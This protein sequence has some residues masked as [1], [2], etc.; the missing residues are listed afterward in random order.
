MLKLSRFLSLNDN[1]VQ[2]KFSRLTRTVVMGI[3][4][5]M[6]TWLCPWASCLPVGIGLCPCCISQQCHW[7]FLFLSHKLASVVAA[8]SRLCHL[9][10]SQGLSVLCWASIRITGPPH[11]FP[12]GERKGLP[13]CGD[14]AV[15]FQDHPLEPSWTAPSTK[16]CRPA[17]AAPIHQVEYQPIC[18]WDVP[19]TCLGFLFSSQHP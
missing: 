11:L 3:K 5:D 15:P 4:Y 18:S 16:G 13:P 8:D 10:W 19:S 17:A 6:T 2:G 7:P 1:W 12:L 9:L 14:R